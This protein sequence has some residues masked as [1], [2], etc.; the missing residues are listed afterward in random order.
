MQVYNLLNSW[1]QESARK[2]TFKALTSPSMDSCCSSLLRNTSDRS[3]S[4]SALRDS[5]WYRE[6]AERDEEVTAARVSSRTGQDR[7]PDP[8][9]LPPL[10]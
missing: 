7:P 2:S 1:A 4:T 3:P 6:S 8:G 9:T 10:S 5:R